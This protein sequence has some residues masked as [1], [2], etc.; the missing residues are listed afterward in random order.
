MDK[1]MGKVMIPS[2][3]KGMIPSMDKSMD[4]RRKACTP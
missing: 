2:V 1:G 4:R 3:D